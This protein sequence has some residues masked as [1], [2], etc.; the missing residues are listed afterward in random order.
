MRKRDERIAA[1]MRI[2]YALSIHSLLKSLAEKDLPIFQ[3]NL[4]TSEIRLFSLGLDI[5]IYTV[6]QTDSI[7]Y[8]P[9]FYLLAKFVKKTDVSE[10]RLTA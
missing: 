7:F 4:P 2:F 1:F 3:E 8:P 9:R 10:L 5:C 6:H